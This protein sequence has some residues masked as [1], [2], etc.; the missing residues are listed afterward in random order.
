MP[1][2]TSAVSRILIVDD[3]P[4]LRMGLVASLRADPTLTVCGEAATPEE[5]LAQVELLEPDAAVVDLSMGGRDGYELIEDLIALR[6]ALR[7]LVYTSMEARLHLRRALRAGAW[8]YLMKGAS[9][10]QLLGALHGVLGGSVAVNEEALRTAPPLE[11]E[12][13]PV[14]G[15]SDREFRIFRMIGAGLKP[16]DIAEELKISPRT[17]NAYRER[18]K[19]KMRFA[20]G[21]ALDRA[22][23][24]FVRAYGEVLPRSSLL[25]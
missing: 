24:D 17:V 19:A 1:G 22:A 21:S 5:A 2:Q 13:S 7:I 18:I 16:A 6:P 14:S 23:F 12:R 4:V 3:H 11:E 15:L 20:D 25:P 9:L 10:E 8:G